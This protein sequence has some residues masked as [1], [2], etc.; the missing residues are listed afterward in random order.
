MTATSYAKSESRSDSILA[1]RA[2]LTHSTHAQFERTK[3]SISKLDVSIGQKMVLSDINVQFKPSAVTALLGPNGAGKSTLLKALCQEISTPR[4]S[5][6]L[7]HSQLADWPRGELA[8]SLAVL[9]QHASLTFPFTVSE[10]VAMGLYPLTISHKEGET[11]VAEQLAQ[12]GLTHLAKRSYP[13][14]SGGEK[15][16]VQ[17]ARVLTQLS[18]SPFPPI[19][20][21]DEPTSA[22]DLAQQH[23]VLELAQNLAH[24]HA[25]TVIVVLHDLN[26]AA[27]YSD[28][29]IVLKQ[30]RIVSEGTPAEALSVDTI[31]EVW[32]YEPVYLAAPQGG[33]PLI[34]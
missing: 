15:Q 7:G 27:R 4:Q 22:L 13:T 10:V 23:R 34:F 28:Q 25:Y 19:L 33:H 14:L 9:P 8:K 16:R 24:Q 30:G 18:Q 32:D 2:H 6:R 31:R 20:L 21:L 5:I 3:L 17:L 11:L 12:V 29:L 1:P 26:Q